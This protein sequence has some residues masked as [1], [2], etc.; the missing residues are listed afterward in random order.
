[1]LIEWQSPRTP[2]GAGLPEAGCTLS[3]LGL[4]HP[5]PQRLREL[6][7]LAGLADAVVVAQGAPGLWADVVTP[8][9]TRRLGA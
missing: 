8:R 5:Q 6:L 1:M 7:A 9:G 3:A 2:A 4:R